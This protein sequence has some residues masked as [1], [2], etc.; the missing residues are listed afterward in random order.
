MTFADTRKS[1]TSTTEMRR[2]E[3]AAVTKG[4]TLNAQFRI[5]DPIAQEHNSRT[6]KIYS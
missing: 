5:C 1:R 3:S 4:G 6:A 2:D